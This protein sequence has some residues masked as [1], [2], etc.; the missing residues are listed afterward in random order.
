MKRTVLSVVLIIIIIVCLICSLFIKQTKEYTKDLFYMDTYINIRFYTSDS[1]KSAMALKEVEQIYSDYHKLSD[2]YNSY[3][4]ITN[5][6][7]ILHNKSSDEYLEIDS[8]LYE[9]LSYGLEWKKKSNGKFD[10]SIGNVIDI[11]KNYRDIGAGIPTSDELNIAKLNTVSNIE[12]KDNNLILNNHPNIDLGA[13]AKGAATEEVGAY[14]ESIGI[15]KYIIN[16]GG[17][18]KV[19]KHYNNSKYSIGIENPDSNGTDIYKVIYGNNISVVTSGGYLRFYEY[20]GEKYHHIIDPDTLMPP[21]YS[22]SVTVICHDSK[23]GDILSTILYLLPIDDAKKFLKNYDDVE[24][25]WYTNDN[26]II[27]TEGFYKYE[28]K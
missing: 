13:I 14:L 18:V 7:S 6:Y 24:A 23:L 3:D 12:L 27:T 11:W 9:M 19:G 2:R 8:R 20:N 1:E 22:K 4:G 17:S 5:L 10:I 28:S 25:I 16:A 15:D 26:Q 21:T